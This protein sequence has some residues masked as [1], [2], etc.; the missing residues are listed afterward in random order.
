MTIDFNSEEIIRELRRQASHL[1]DRGFFEEAISQLNQCL[2]LEDE[3]E[4]RAD[5]LCELGFCFLRMGW[6]DDGMRTFSQHLETSPFDNDARFYL[7]SAYNAMGWI[8]ESIAEFKKI[9]TADPTDALS[10][11]GLGLCY[12]DKGWLKE[13]L[14]VMRIAKEQAAIHGNQEEKDI[15]EKSLANLEKEIEEGGEDKMRRTFLLAILLAILEGRR[16]KIP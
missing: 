8:N 7:A 1:I 12:K 16:K 6:Y 13:S 10:Y 2:H 5:I 15:I 11:H 9:L 3:P 14:G 4:A